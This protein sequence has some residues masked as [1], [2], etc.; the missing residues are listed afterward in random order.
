VREV[1]LALAVVRQLADSVGG[2]DSYEM[3]GQCD[4]AATDSQAA[5][6]CLCP[7]RALGVSA[8]VQDCLLGRPDGVGEEAVVR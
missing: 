7:D 1:T 5:R 2:L 4:G 8:D 6:F 3:L